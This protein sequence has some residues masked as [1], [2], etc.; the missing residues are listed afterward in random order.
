MSELKPEQ[1]W[2]EFDAPTGQL[3]RAVTRCTVFACAVGLVVLLGMNW[4]FR[5]SA[6]TGDVWS[7][8][9]YF[10]GLQVVTGFTTA[11]YAAM[12]TLYGVGLVLLVVRPAE[13][14]L[15]VVGAATGLVSTCVVL[16]A[17][18]G[19][20]WDG[21][22]KVVDYRWQ[23]APYLALVLWIVALGLTGRIRWLIRRG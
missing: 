19:D 5:Y 21:G 17:G 23:A 22:T 14:L 8:D 3:A 9:K 20:R 12:V 13:H 1:V 6:D 16:L 15:S 18:P 10:T 7:E 2:A 4:L 11:V